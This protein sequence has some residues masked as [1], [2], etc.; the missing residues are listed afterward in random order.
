MPLISLVTYHCGMN[1]LPV[2]VEW[3]GR[4][5]ARESEEGIARSGIQI[6]SMS[7]DFRMRTCDKR[8]HVTRLQKGNGMTWNPVEH[9][10]LCIDC[11]FTA[12]LLCNC[13]LTVHLQHFD[14]AVTQ[15]TVHWLY[16]CCCFC[17]GSS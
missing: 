9:I 3:I 11:A 10:G 12:F 14:C 7:G 2:L 6:R 17:L 15:Q 13:A 16:I 1:V 4:C 8:Y 5:L